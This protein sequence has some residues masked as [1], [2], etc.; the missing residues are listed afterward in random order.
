MCLMIGAAFAVKDVS[1]SA[2][3]DTGASRTVGGHAI[4]ENLIFSHLLHWAHICGS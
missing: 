2:L 3:L 4:V 1:G